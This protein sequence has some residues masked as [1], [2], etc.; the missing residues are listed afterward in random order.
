MRRVTGLLRKHLVSLVLLLGYMYMALVVT[1][2][3]RTIQSQKSL[4]GT[5]FFDSTQLNLIRMEKVAK[6]YKK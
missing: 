1:E 2:Q 6:S 4:I 3:N 5:L